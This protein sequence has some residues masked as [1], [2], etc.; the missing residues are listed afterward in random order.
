MTE[1][2]ENARRRDERSPVFLLL[3]D[4][5]VYPRSDSDSASDADTGAEEHSAKKVKTQPVDA[6][7]RERKEVQLQADWKSILDVE[8][9]AKRE[10]E[11][12]L[13]TVDG[14]DLVEIR[15]PRF[16]AG[17]TIYETVR[18][19]KTHPDVKKYGSAETRSVNDISDCAQTT[20]PSTSSIVHSRQPP[21]NPRHHRR[22]R[23]SSTTTTP[24]STAPTPAKPS[25]AP[26][27]RKPRQSLESMNA[28]LVAASKG[29]KMTTIEK[30]AHDWSAHTSRDASLAEQLAANRKE[31]GGGFLEKKEFLG[32]VGERRDELLEKGKSTRRR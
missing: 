24:T 8:E 29:K 28:A 17:E 6:E 32:R 18:L 16:F 10:R 19:S 20:D 9:E 25:K 31:N 27:R 30:S 26:L 11:Q 23:Q 5:P 7:E 1:V 3:V 15:R 12:G 21:Y 4:I 22:Q 14:E 2:E 13:K